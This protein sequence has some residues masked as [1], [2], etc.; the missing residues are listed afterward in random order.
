M[1][2]F[3]FREGLAIFLGQSKLSPPGSGDASALG[4]GNS[5]YLHFISKCFQ[6]PNRRVHA[7][8]LL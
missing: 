8:I 7:C 6:V 2:A 1:L 3:F 5:A 4:P